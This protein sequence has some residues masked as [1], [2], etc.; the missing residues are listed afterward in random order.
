LDDIESIEFEFI[1]IETVMK[2]IDAGEFSQSLHIS[3][4]FL[5][6]RKR[7]LLARAYRA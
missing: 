6:L 3:S 5:A 1:E 7:G 2:M 4:I